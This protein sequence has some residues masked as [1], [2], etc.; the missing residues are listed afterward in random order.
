MIMHVQTE[1][2]KGKTRKKTERNI[3]TSR[4][5]NEGCRKKANKKIFKELLF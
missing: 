4:A 3:L 5:E 1:G 2:I